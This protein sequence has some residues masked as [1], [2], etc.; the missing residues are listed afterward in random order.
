V[1]VSN[2]PFTDVNALSAGFVWFVTDDFGE[3]WLST[4]GVASPGTHYNSTA[5][6]CFSKRPRLAVDHDNPNRLFVT[7]RCEGN[8]QFGV[9]EDAGVN[10]DISPNFF[11][12]DE[13]LLTGLNDV[14]IAGGSTLA[15]GNGGAILV[16]NNGRDVYFQRADNDNGD[17]LAT[18]KLD[19]ANAVVVGKG[20][21]IVE[22]AQ[23]NTIPDV[24]APAGTISGPTTATA[25]TPATF[26]ANLADDAGGSGINPA[27]IAWSATGVPSATGNP[28]ALT[29]PSA[30]FY[31]VRVDFK[32]NAGNAGSATLGVTVGAP[33]PP[34]P[35]AKPAPT[36]LTKT[37]TSNGG[38][39]S[40]GVPRACVHPG[41]TFTVTLTF[42][43]QKRKGNKFVKVTRTD[44][45]IGAKR[46]KIDKQAPFRQTLRVT[47]KAKAGSTIS[48]KARAYIKVKRGK[49]PKKSITSKIRVC[50]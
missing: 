31:T 21:R 23:A 44:F 11:A 42:K 30:G 34:P 25:G 24:V 49:S 3:R 5:A 40:F 15:V 46:V 12:G 47:V 16:T 18:D 4:D 10:F 20:G 13:H 28:V 2:S 37:V 14:A 38:S 22:T 33:P 41:Q 9:S 26:T 48:L 32:D 6:N 7:D 50:G 35:P 17:W 8:L 39:I 43:K 36:T 1:G 19:A 45:Y 29:F 27:S